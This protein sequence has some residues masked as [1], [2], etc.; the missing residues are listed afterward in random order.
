[1]SEIQFT[2][3]NWKQERIGEIMR[4]KVKGHGTIQ[5]SKE[6]LNIISIAFD[7]ASELEKLNNREARS[8]LFSEFSSE[9]FIALEETGYY[10]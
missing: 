6:M 2:R 10:K 7:N 5:A 4:V 3:V 9:I 8:K 1:M